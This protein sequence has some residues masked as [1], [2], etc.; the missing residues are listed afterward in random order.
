[1]NARIMRVCNE[2]SGGCKNIRP[3]VLILNAALHENKEHLQFMV[4]SYSIDGIRNLI[5]SSKINFVRSQQKKTR[6]IK[7]E[8][9][10]III[11]E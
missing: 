1:M 7:N 5:G 8:I 6:N 4:N 2:F 9:N 10:L 3:G 11:E